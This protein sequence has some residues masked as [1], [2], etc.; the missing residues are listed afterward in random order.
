MYAI[1][2]YYA[3]RD[4]CRL[5]IF[6]ELAICGYPPQDLLERPSFLRAHDLALTELIGTLP[7]ID[8]MF[9]CVERCRAEGGKPLYNTAVVARGGKIVFRARK[10]LLPSYDVFDET[11]YFE[12]GPPSQLYEIDGLTF[13]V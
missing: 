13:V 10:R 3:W 12:P 8:V 1:R 6:P 4:G 11:R 9:G 7:P 2:S 5:V